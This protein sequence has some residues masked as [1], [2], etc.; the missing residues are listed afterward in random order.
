MRG[1]RGRVWGGKRRKR[2]GER[3]EGDSARGPIYHFWSWFL[4]ATIQL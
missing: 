4:D 2:E 3:E 1:E